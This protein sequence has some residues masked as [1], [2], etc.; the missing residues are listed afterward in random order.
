VNRFPVLQSSDA[1][2]NK[3]VSYRASFA[4][5]LLRKGKELVA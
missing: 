4:V 1:M 2:G 5:T 3:V